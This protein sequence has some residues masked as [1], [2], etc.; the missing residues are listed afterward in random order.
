MEHGTHDRYSDVIRLYANHTIKHQRIADQQH[1]LPK[2]PKERRQKVAQL[3]K[4][5][6]SIRWRS[7]QQHL[8][9]NFMLKT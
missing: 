2:V 8:K 5:N 7:H 6:C 1:D 9:K 3:T 4:S